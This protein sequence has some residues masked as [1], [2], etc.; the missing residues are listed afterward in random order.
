MDDHSD[1]EMPREEEADEIESVT[2][3]ETAMESPLSITIPP[4]DDGALSASYSEAYEDDDQLRNEEHLLHVLKQES[5]QYADQIDCL[6]VNIQACLDGDPSAIRFSF[7]PPGSPRSKSRKIR[8]ESTGRARLEILRNKLR[9]AEDKEKEIETTMVRMTKRVL[10]SDLNPGEGKDSIREK[11]SPVGSSRISEVPFDKEI[12]AL[13][14]K[15]QLVIVEKEEIHMQM[16]Q[17]MAQ[18]RGQ[19]TA[20]LTLDDDDGVEDDKK[21]YF[22]FS[23]ATTE[24]KKHPSAPLSM[25]SGASRRSQ[26]PAA[27]SK[28]IKN[29]GGLQHTSL[30]RRSVETPECF[31]KYSPYHPAFKSTDLLDG[32]NNELGGM[33]NGCITAR[34][35]DVNRKTDLSIFK[36]PSLTR[37]PPSS[38]FPERYIGLDNQTC[39]RLKRIFGRM[40]GTP[41]S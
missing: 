18:L 22:G 30:R 39:E 6:S 13:T 12:F 5:V 33:K 2:Y 34:N 10:Q 31:D 8:E 25:S 32:C 14:H 26:T 11:F 37:R 17:L 9:F 21:P 40:D 38:G 24:R 19:T 28:R 4:T 3:S 29:G 7:S 16:S 27:Q 23:T 36:S 15:L 35:A 1:I 41:S 20:E